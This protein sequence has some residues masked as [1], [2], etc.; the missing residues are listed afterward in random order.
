MI[1]DHRWR[2]LI[3]GDPKTGKTSLAETCVGPRLIIDA[4]GGTD[5][6]AKPRLE[7]AD[8]AQ[9]PPVPDDPDTSVVLFARD[10][11]QVHLAHQW[12]QSGNHP[13]NSYVMDTLTDV[14]RRA[15]D[16]IKGSGMDQGAWGDLLD[17]MMEEMT[18]V[19][20]LTK[21]PVRPL[22]TVVITAHSMY[23]EKSNL[24][25]PQVQGGLRRDVGGLYDTIA[26]LR[27][28][29][30]AGDGRVGRELIID[31][32]PGIE[33]GDRTKILRRRFNGVVP[34]HL[35]DATDRITPDLTDMLKILN[36]EG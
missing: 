8:A 7:W 16:T 12:L 25:R 19:R 27:V 18:M 13:F 32:L 6:G 24:L 11:H 5:F 10:W 31:A 36:G 20:N 1:S 3:H 26:H 14:Q 30:G 4:E 33:A 34:L 17:K 15:K 23:D 2:V 28:G 9:A 29:V 22:W 35:D 21:H